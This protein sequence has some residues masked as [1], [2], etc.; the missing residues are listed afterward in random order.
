MRDYQ[1]LP[2]P[3]ERD[4]AAAEEDVLNALENLRTDPCVHPRLADGSSHLH[5]WFIKFVSAELFAYDPEAHQ[6]APL[7]TTESGKL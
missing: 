5:G 4:T 3:A 7:V 1:N 2:Q 6:F